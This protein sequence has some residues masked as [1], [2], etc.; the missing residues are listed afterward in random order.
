MSTAPETHRSTNGR[1]MPHRHLTL[2]RYERALE[3]DLHAAMQ[4]RDRAARC[5]S[6]AEAFAPPPLGPFLEAWA[7]P[8]EADKPDDWR[9]ALR[10]AIAPS[11]HRKPGRSLRLARTLLAA[12]VLVVLMLGTALP[13]AASIGP[14]SVLYPV[15]A[16]EEEAHWR[17]TP[18]RDRASLE[19]DLTASYLWQARMSAARHDQARYQE[20]MQR[21]FIWAERLKADVRK[22]SPAQ[23]PGARET[24]QTALS[25]VPPLTTAGPDS[26]QAYRVQ[27]IMEE[28]EADSEAG[29]SQHDITGQNSSRGQ[30][31]QPGGSAEPRASPEK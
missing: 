29:D 12:G 11:A 26:Q 27:S 10:R 22:A 16:M 18:E 8:A 9:L 30:G 19:A 23:R 2:E 1:E 21:V 15:R 4:M 17:L 20:A 3:E 14:G 28:V 6:C 7:L 24:V 25:L 31:Q 5:R 13:V